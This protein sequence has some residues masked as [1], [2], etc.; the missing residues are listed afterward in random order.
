MVVFA[1][2]TVMVSA[3]IGSIIHPY[4]PYQDTTLTAVRMQAFA[5]LSLHTDLHLGFARAYIIVRLARCVFYGR[6]V[7]LALLHVRRLDDTVALGVV[8]N[9]GRRDG[10]GSDRGRQGRREQSLFHSAPLMRRAA[11]LA[12]ASPAGSRTYFDIL[13][14]DILS[15]AIL[16]FFFMESL[17][18]VSLVIESFF[19]SSAK[20]AGASGVMARPAAINAERKKL[21][22]IGCSPQD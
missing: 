20:A 19:M 11:G 3:V 2:V 1:G 18:I 5:K 6:P 9:G 16:S 14:L 10:A 12:G 7:L 15:L 22:F 21:F 13:S 4:N 8:R 17:A